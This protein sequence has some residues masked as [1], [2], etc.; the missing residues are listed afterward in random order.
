VVERSA[1]NRLVVG[2]NP[3]SGAISVSRHLRSSAFKDFVKRVHRSKR[4]LGSSVYISNAR[5]E[6][7]KI[8]P[9]TLFIALKI[10]LVTHAGE[11]K[12]EVR[13][14]VNDIFLRI[15]RPISAVEGFGS[16]PSHDAVRLSVL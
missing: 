2:S 10:G 8:L 1:V 9:G 6:L 15:T 14:S 12:S 3:T 4:Q 7:Q 13:A 11:D 5:L 16:S